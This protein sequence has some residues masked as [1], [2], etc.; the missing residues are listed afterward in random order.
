MKY[1][2]YELGDTRYSSVFFV[3]ARLTFCLVN[4]SNKIGF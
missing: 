2:H 3:E 4:I 1:I